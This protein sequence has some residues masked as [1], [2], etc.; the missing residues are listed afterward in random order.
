MTAT[1]PPSPELLSEIVVSKMLVV[2]Y[3][4]MIP[5]PRANVLPEETPVALLPVIVLL[6][7]V[8]LSLRLIM[9]PPLLP[10]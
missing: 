2:P 7:I 4:T 5:P 8:K 3:A 10:A 6:R 1:P 9:P